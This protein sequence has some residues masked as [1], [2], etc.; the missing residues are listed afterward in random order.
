MMR[1]KRSHN[2]LQKTIQKR[3]EYTRK[4]GGKRKPPKDLPRIRVEHD[5]D[6]ADKLCSCGHK[7]HKIKELTSEQYDIVPAQFRI[8]KHVRFV[9]GCTC[10]AKPKTAPVP[11]TI[12]PKSQVSAS[13]LATVAVQKFEDALIGQDLQ[14][15][16]WCSFYR[17][18]ALKLDD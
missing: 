3:I 9:Y 15:S 2:F 4:K 7:M 10:G 1:P 18:N 12:L 8:I 6:E 14:E 5:I 16:I 11:P 13:F 17:H